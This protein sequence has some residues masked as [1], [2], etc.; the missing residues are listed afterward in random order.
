MPYLR[1]LA[2]LV[3][4][5]GRKIMAINREDFARDCADEA[6]RFGVNMH[7]LLALAELLSGINDDSDGDRIGPFRIK[8]VDWDARGSDPELEVNL[9]PAHINRPGLQCVYAALQTL[10]AQEKFLKQSRG[11][12]PNADQ[13]Y[14]I[15][16]N[17]PVPE[18]KSL[19]DALGST[20]QLVEAAEK[21]ALEGLDLG[22]LVGPIKIDWLKPKQQTMAVKIV[23]A[24]KAEGCNVTAQA[25]ALANAMGESSLNPNLVSRPPEHSVGLFQCNTN[26]GV[27]DGKS[28]TFLKNPDNNIALIIAE[29]KNR[30]PAFK[31]STD[32][33]QAVT[34]FVEKVERPANPTADVA[35][36][37]KFAVKFL[38]A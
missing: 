7:Y 13:L 2:I 38:P 5:G 23:N 18:G 3:C 30:A 9:L 22:D 27:G 4:L 26:G 16:P 10:R 6:F 12:F 15:W 25:A 24:F 34:L 33:K 20:Q 17:Q 37:M 1:R 14:A 11:K 29:M 35:I 19:L 8:Q 28:E 31:T 21:E 36:R 32:L